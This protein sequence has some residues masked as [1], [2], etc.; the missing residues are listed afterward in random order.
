M[1]YTTR[2]LQYVMKEEVI[3]AVHVLIVP[4]NPCNSSRLSDCQGCTITSPNL[5]LCHSPAA[6]Q[7]EQAM[8][9]FYLNGI[10]Y[11]SNGHASS[12]MDLDE[13]E[14]TNAGHFLFEYVEDPQFYTANKEK[15]IKHHP[16][17][18]LTLIINVSARGCA[19]YVTKCIYTHCPFYWEF[20][21]TCSFLPGS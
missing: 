2:K 16:G 11:R 5:I 14:E 7:S 21:Y 4:A 15:L 18:P 19:D 6:S 12:D 17:E 20:L 8:A 13:E 1:T 9:Q 3:Q 10:L